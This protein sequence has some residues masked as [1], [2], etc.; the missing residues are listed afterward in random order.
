MVFIK[1]FSDII[2]ALD[3]RTLHWYKMSSLAP[4]SV[5][6]QSPEW[7]L[8]LGFLPYITDCVF[9]NISWKCCD[10]TCVCYLLSH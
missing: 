5:N 8:G 6:I 9:A 1:P 7:A 10:R 2:I 4:L 3:L